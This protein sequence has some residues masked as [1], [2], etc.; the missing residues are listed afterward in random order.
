[1]EIPIASFLSFNNCPIH[2][3]DIE[4]FLQIFS[5]MKVI[6]RDSYRCIAGSFSRIGNICGMGAEVCGVHKKSRFPR[7]E[8]GSFGRSY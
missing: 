5:E 3:G 2:P 7:E 1:M 4:G 8:S 6:S